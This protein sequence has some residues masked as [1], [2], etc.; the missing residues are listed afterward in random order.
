[1]LTFRRATA[2]TVAVAMAMASVGQAQDEKKG[3]RGQGGGGGF[4]MPALGLLENADVQKEL[5]LTEDDKAALALLKKELEESDKKFRESL[6]DVPREEIRG[7][8]TD[9][10]KARD[11]MIGEVLGS[12]MERYKQIELQAY[13]LG[14]ALMSPANQEKLKITE[15]QKT[16]IRE[17]TMAGFGGGRGKRGEKGDKGGNAGSDD[18]EARKKAGEDRRKKQTEDLMAILTDDQKKTWKEM[19]GAPITF[20]LPRMGGFGGGN[21]GTRPGGEG[22]KGK[23]PNPNP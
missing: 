12:K 6:K 2:L 9:R 20:E 10:T 7:K 3:R 18:P 5:K 8:M 15:D 11:K 23:R 19:I 22:G 21:R 13:G 14:F 16:K 17:V 1:M 4:N